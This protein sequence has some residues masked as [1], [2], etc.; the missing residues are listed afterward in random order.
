M[1]ERDRT[2]GCVCVRVCVCV[3]VCAC[4]CVCV[5]ICERKKQCAC[6]S[7]SESERAREVRR[8][9][10]SVSVSRFTCRHARP[11]GERRPVGREL[12]RTVQ[13]TIREQLLRSNEKQF[14]G[15]LV[16]KARRLLYHSTLGRE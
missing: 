6:V 3:C 10:E 7:D 11:A 15:G 5:C 1:R 13:F 14:Q 4:V 16:F 2:R 8:L 12:Y 9:D